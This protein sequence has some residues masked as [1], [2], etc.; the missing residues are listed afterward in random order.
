MSKPFPLETWWFHQQQYLEAPPCTVK[1]PRVE[2]LVESFCSPKRQ[3][4]PKSSLFLSTT[5]TGTVALVFTDPPLEYRVHILYPIHW[6]SP[7]A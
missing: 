1:V 2:W 7:F 5:A 4:T 3:M 6:P